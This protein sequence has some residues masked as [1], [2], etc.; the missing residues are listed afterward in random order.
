[1]PNMNLPDDTSQLGYRVDLPESKVHPC[2]KCS[3][4]VA[5]QTSSKG[6]F[7]LVN[8]YYDVD[9]PVCFRAD[10]HSKTCAANLPEN[11]I[12]EVCNVS[13]GIKALENLA[14]AG[15]DP[16]VI[17]ENSDEVDWEQV[18]LDE[19]Y[20]AENPVVSVA[21]KS[22]HVLD[23]I[24]AEMA[25]LE[26]EVKLFTENF[27]KP[28]SSFI[29][30]KKQEESDYLKEVE[31]VI[32]Q[33]REDAHKA[34]IEKNDYEKQIKALQDRLH[35]LS[36]EKMAHLAALAAQER[37]QAIYDS[38]QEAWEAMPWNSYMMDFQREDILSIVQAF[39]DGKNGMMNANDRGMG[40]TFETGAAL[41]LLTVLFE[42]DHNRKPHVLWLTK[43][44]LVGQTYREHLRWNPERKMIV[45][46]A[47]SIQTGAL[48][49]TIKMGATKETRNFQLEMAVQ[50]NSWVISNYDV[51][52]TTP[53]ILD[54][55]WDILVVDEV[56]K[57]KGGANC[58]VRYC[59]HGK[60]AEKCRATGLWRKTKQIIDEHKPFFLPLSGTPIQNHPKD[61][62]SY[63]HLFNAKSFPSPK[64]FEREYCYGYGI[65]GYKVDW[66]RLITVMKDQV[67]RRRKDEVGMDLPD[68]IVEFILDEL[69]EEATYYNQMQDEFIIELEE[70]GM[71][72][73]SASFILP[74]INYLSQILQ[75]PGGV[76]WTNSKGVEQTLPDVPT[77]KMNTCLE[78]IEELLAE[79]EQVV[80][81]STFN[82]PLIEMARRVN[83]ANYEFGSTGQFVKA[84]VFTG[85][86]N[87]DGTGD[88]IQQ[89]FQQGNTQVL[90]C[91]LEAGGEG[92]NL[93]KNPTQWAGGACHAIFMGLWWNP[94][95]NVQAEDRIH[96]KG[97]TDQVTI[98]V[99][100]A[101]NSVDAMIAEINKKKQEMQDGIMESEEI[102]PAVE[103][104][105]LLKGT[106]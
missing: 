9:Q 98:H 25:R 67:I 44:G 30:Q 16:V 48:Y 87:S 23:D 93:Q 56:H 20:E 41:D 33:M 13:D 2:K 85:K 4:P 15:L 103:W 7:Y 82:R 11:V 22:H 94:A 90:F 59:E 45:L 70:M 26:E 47:T 8:V 80:V 17:S 12:A 29:E 42:R 74:K 57:L 34:L 68:K 35:G 101:E 10:F 72:P 96:R 106:K 58:T 5:W 39:V 89:R 18:H 36:Q 46:G 21:E 38:L 32:Q 54:V 78:L 1:M 76:K 88:D 62:W 65:E 81:F 61:M 50:L 92:L 104:A 79:G 64:R 84:E 6:K 40:K 43:K 97:Q 28:L 100:Q 49:D 63:L 75:F 66:E 71:E 37:I 27:V 51:L 73:L 55:P 53:A 102:R 86:Q 95:K 60:Y 99:I 52:N 105:A 24:N 19:A 31:R 91:N 77:M 14:N 3:A 69:G 83:E